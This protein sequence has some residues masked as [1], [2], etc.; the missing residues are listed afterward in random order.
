M[1]WYKKARLDSVYNIIRITDTNGI[2]KEDVLKDVK[3]NVIEIKADSPEQARYLAK[4]RYT[5][6]AEWENEFAGRTIV[7]R[8]NKERMQEIENYKDI[9]ETLKKKKEER[10]QAIYEN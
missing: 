8:I 1:N 2:A 3:G 5:K 9:S 7:A 4:Q 6:L 10:A